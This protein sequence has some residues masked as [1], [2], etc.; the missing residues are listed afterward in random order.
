MIPPIW[1][2]F[3]LCEEEACCLFN[4]KEKIMSISALNISSFSA[5]DSLTNEVVQPESYIKHDLE[6]LVDPSNQDKDTFQSV[7]SKYV[8]SI[9]Q[10]RV[11]IQE[12]ANHASRLTPSDMVGLQKTVGEYSINVQLLSKGMSVASK[13]LNQLVSM[14]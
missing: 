2:R 6:H 7:L 3:C 4:D 5:E 9:Q 11:D 12:Y 10:S 14:Q 8:D 13:A 1:H